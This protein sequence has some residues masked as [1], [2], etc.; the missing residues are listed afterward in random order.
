MT[1]IQKIDL[2]SREEGVNRRSFLIGAGAAGLALGYSALPNALGVTG[3]ALAAG[4]FDPSVWYSIAP[5]GIVTVNVGKAE[6]GQHV[7]SSVAQMIADELEAD[8]KD[9][10]IA[11]L[12]NDP[13]YNDPVLGA[14]VTGGSWSIIFNFDAMRRAG[15]A[16][17]MT[18]IETAAA[19]MGVAAAECHANNSVVYHSKSSKSMRYAQ[20][21]ATGKAKKAW[22]P[23]ELKAIKLK[24]ADQY[25]LIGQPVD[26]KS[27]V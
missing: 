4:N 20:I 15:A 6:M 27:V 22:T 5:N 23:D 19:E 24:S 2:P 21:V 8:W 9:M 7:S 16:G 10:R 26:R 18:L 13:K 1:E 17:R 14:Q 11:F 25:S 12:T 3:E